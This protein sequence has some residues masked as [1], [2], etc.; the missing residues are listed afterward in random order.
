MQGPEGTEEDLDCDVGVVY[1]VRSI[2]SVVVMVR[3]RL[4]FARRLKYRWIAAQL[5]LLDFSCSCLQ[6][7]AWIRTFWRAIVWETS[8]VNIR[9]LID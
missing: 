1:L 3:W 2:E 4:S 5:Q 9:N 8:I 6:N 7:N